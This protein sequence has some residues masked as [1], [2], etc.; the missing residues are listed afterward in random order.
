MVKG[1][2]VTLGDRTGTDNLTIG[3]SKRGRRDI[4]GIQEVVIQG[5]KIGTGGVLEIGMT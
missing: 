5:D 2:I 3:G 4:T 1:S